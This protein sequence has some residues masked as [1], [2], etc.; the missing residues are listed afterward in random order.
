MLSSLEESIDTPLAQQIRLR[1][2]GR[3]SLTVR[4]S[5]VH[6]VDSIRAFLAASRLLHLLQLLNLALFF[7]FLDHL[8]NPL[9]LVE[10]LLLFLPYP[11]L[12]ADQGRVEGLLQIQI[13]I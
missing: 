3:P 1:L 13:L 11:A 9:A 12:I 10:R 7:P 2:L 5:T 4:R 6:P 8:L